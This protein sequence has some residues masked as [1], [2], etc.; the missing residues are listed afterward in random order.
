MLCLTAPLHQ[1]QLEQYTSDDNNSTFWM[2]GDK[3]SCPTRMDCSLPVSRRWSKYDRIW[4]KP[5]CCLPL[6]CSSRRWCGSPTTSSAPQVAH[7]SI[8]FAG[9]LA[10]SSCRMSASFSWHC[11]HHSHLQHTIVTHVTLTPV[12]WTEQRTGTRNEPDYMQYSS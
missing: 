8:A 4:A 3:T 6:T 11:Q 5:L 9:S 7:T 2:T 12:T 1:S 10:I